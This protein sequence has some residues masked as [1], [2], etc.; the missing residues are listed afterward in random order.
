L[1]NRINWKQFWVDMLGVL[2]G[3]TIAFQLQNWK[4]NRANNSVREQYLINLSSDLYQDSLELQA[5]VDTMQH[6]TRMMSLL[7]RDMYSP[8]PSDSIFEHTMGMFSASRFDAFNTTYQSM[9]SSGDMKLIKNFEL[10][11][12]IIDL[13]ERQHFEIEAFDE[14]HLN[15]FYDHIYPVLYEDV[16]FTGP[17]NLQNVEFLKDPK[18][19]NLAHAN[20][21]L[22]QRKLSAYEKAL[23]ATTAL[24]EKLR[25]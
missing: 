25:E 16:I 21:G 10:R 19:V 13:Y 3:I 11:K 18:F 1:S 8:Q 14:S 12:E 2:I 15:V 5:M 6:Q 24:R 9:I 20:N 7:V 23:T 22:L 4:E 17:R